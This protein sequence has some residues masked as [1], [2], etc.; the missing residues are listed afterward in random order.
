MTHYLMDE[1]R[2]QETSTPEQEYSAIPCNSCDRE[3]RHKILAET[4][5]HWEYGSGAVDVW[6]NY[7]I[8]QCQGC[9][10]ISFCESLACSEDIEYDEHNE[11]YQPITRKFFPNRIAGRPTM[12]D[13]YFL[14]QGV[15]EIYQEAHGALCAELPVM[16]GFGIRAIVEAVCKD[17]SMAGNNLKER[18]DALAKAG[19]ITSAGA[20]I[21]HHLR[22]MGNAAAHEMKAHSP[23]EMN[24]AFDVVEY[25]LQGVYILPRQAEM[26]PK[27]SH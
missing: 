4:K 19:L 26:L 18:I 12:Q 3:T 8:V 13:V 22:F 24:A 9:L 17:K 15:Q 11:A 1:P 14:P 21:L 20:E 7:Q 6:G 10:T 27:R 2:E 16:A 5:V 25:L 23:T